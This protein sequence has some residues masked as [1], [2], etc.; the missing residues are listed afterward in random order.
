MKCSGDEAREASLRW[1]GHVQRRFSQYISKSMLRL[2]LAD[3]R[4][5]GRAMRSFID[6]VKENMKLVGVR[7]E[8]AED[9]RVR[10]MQMIPPKGTAERRS[11]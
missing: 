11:T 1:F 5:R 9:E 8:D 10:W 7:V 2:E 3:R 6:A 4:P